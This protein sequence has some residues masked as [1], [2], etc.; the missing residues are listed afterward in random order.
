MKKNLVIAIDGYSSCGKS[1]LA[2]AL[3]KKLGFIY[4]DSGAMYRAVTLYFLR[5]NIDITDDA[6]VVDALQHIEL[7][8]HSRDYESHITLNGEEVSDEIRLMPVSENVSEVSAHKI[9]RHE[10][11]KQQQRMGKSKNI[12]MD[13][14]DIGTTVFPDA[15]VKFFMTA[16]PK[17]RAERRFKEL[18]SKGNNK[19]TLEE[20]FENLAHRD[21]ADTT[22]KESPLVRADDAI[23]LDNT[24]LTQEEQLDFALERVQ[25]FLVH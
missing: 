22:R 23:I 21:Y 5:N 2:K 25:P 11:V 18:E 24:D 8:F 16:D 6:K 9:V 14:R 20:V 4:V 10:M 12:V 1:T 19:T 3:A 7:N 17:I 13:G 15:P